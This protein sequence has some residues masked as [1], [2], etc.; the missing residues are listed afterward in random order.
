LDSESRRTNGSMSSLNSSLSLP[1]SRC[2]CSCTRHSSSLCRSY[3]RV[4]S[5]CRFRNRGT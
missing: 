3:P 2:C 1:T 4:R 5:H